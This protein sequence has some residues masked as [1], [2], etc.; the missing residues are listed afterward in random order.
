MR[1][2]DGDFLRH[3]IHG[4]G[5]RKH[6]SLATMVTHGFKDGE[7][8][9][10]I[11]SIKR[12]RVLDRNTHLNES[13]KMNH[14]GGL[15][16][17]KD[18]VE[19]CAITYIALNE[20]PPLHGPLVAVGKIVE[21]NGSIAASGQSLASVTTDESG[22]AGNEDFLFMRSLYMIHPRI[23]TDLPSPNSR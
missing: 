2:G 21:N 22:T 16:F 17:G 11:I 19:E 23:Q 4:G 3:A 5:G 6:K 9:T 1:L 15:I 14:A 20:R 12:A 7:G 18:I 13:G 10:G 8:A